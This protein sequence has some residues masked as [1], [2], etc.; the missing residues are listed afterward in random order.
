MGQKTYLS[1][2]WGCFGGV[3]GVHK[4]SENADLLGTLIFIQKCVYFTHCEMRFSHFCVLKRE[5][6]LFPRSP[7]MNL[8]PILGLKKTNSIRIPS[9]MWSKRE[10]DR[11]IKNDVIMV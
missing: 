8:S 10:I 7:T 5:S 9:R 1:N 2:V 4:R 3:K 11:I 6:H